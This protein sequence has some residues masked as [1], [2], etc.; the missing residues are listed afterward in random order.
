MQVAVQSTEQPA[1]AVAD[2]P[3]PGGKSGAGARRS[4]KTDDTGHT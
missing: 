1:A 2:E 3:G 4:R